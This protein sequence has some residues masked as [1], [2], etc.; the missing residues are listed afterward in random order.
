[1]EL[2]IKDRLYIPAFLPKQGTFKEFNLKKEI[3]RKTSISEHER[4]ELNLHENPDSKRIEW[5]VQKESPLHVDF[6]PEE[7]SYLKEVCEKLSD[8][9]LP[10][11]MW[12]TIEA[13]YND[14]QDI[15]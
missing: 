9:Q 15:K 12:S 8:E 11:D 2:S 6:T 3:R 10:D 13:L 7:L 14:M 4:Q 5:D 1:M